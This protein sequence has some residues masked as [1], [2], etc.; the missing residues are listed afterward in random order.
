[1][2]TKLFTDTSTKLILNTAQGLPLLQNAILTGYCVLGIVSF[3]QLMGACHTHTYLIMIKAVLSIATGNQERK[4][5]KNMFQ[6]RLCLLEE[7]TRWN[8]YNSLEMLNKLH[9]Q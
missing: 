1:M 8:I 9:C 2:G 6:G 4:K 7:D 3:N 5:K